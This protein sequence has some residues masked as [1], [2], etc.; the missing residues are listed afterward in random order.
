MEVTEAPLASVE[1]LI[2]EDSRTQAMLL[3]HVLEARGYK[4]AAASCGDEALAALGQRRPTLVISDINMPGMDGYEL[5]RRIKGRE[6]LRDLPVFLLTTLSD[7]KDVIRG[8]ECGASGFLTKPYQEDMLLA[9]IQY[10]LTNMELRRGGTG[11]AA[12]QVHFAGRRYTIASEKQQILD[13]LLSMYDTAVQQNRDLKAIGVQLQ[14]QKDELARSNAELE[15]FAYVASHD[16]QEPL[17]KINAFGRMLS[18]D[19]SS[20]LSANGLDYVTRMVNAADRMMRL[21]QDLLTYARVNTRG[22]DL[23]PVALRPVVMQALDDLGE[24]LRESGGRV[25]VENLPSVQADARQMYQLFQNLIGNALKFV[26]KGQAPVVRVSGRDTGL[27]KVEI[28][29]E[30]NG[31]GFDE[32]D[33]DRIFQP[34]QRLHTRD[35]YPGS[36][37]GLA[38]CRK[39]V[40]RHGG[41][42]T[43]RSRPGAG[44]AFHVSLLAAAL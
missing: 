12:V 14:R 20:D 26:A 9:R 43:A 10:I 35:E 28:V 21:V 2:V 13:F 30:D 40:Q 18:E 8:L 41:E 32:K 1:V 11:E 25:D 36:G 34:F 33:L 19:C 17:R 27:G 24:R 29:V 15:Q 31:I 6:E 22:T 39:I 16:L 23:V 3:R 42:I 7:P 38:V 37:I 44:A 4:V 5:C